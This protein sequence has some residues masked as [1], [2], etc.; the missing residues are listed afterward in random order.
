MKKNI[1]K[2]T[3]KTEREIA[4]EKARKGLLLN[5]SQRG[6]LISQSTGILP[7]TLRSLSCGRFGSL[8]GRFSTATIG[9]AKNRRT[10]RNDAGFLMWVYAM[11]LPAYEIA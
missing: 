2:N 4:M 6:L 5:E 9:A 7:G 10:E 11:S 3:P 8:A 1:E